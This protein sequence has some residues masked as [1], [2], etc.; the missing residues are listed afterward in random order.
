MKGQHFDE[1]TT[2]MHTRLLLTLAA[3]FAL[4]QSAWAVDGETL[5]NQSIVMAA[6][7]FPYQITQSGSYKL[8]G[9]LV[10]T[11]NVDA[12]EI[13]A[14]NVTLDLNGFTIS[15]NVTTGQSVGVG[16]GNNATTVRNGTISGF[17]TAVV[18]G[19]TSNIVE[20][21]KVV[22]SGTGFVLSNA[23]VRRNAVSTTTGVGIQ[24]FQCVITE[25]FVSE[26]PG[27]ALQIGTSLYGS[28]VLVAA[29]PVADFIG[30]GPNVS[31]NNNSCNGQ[32]C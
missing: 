14:S 6:G 11:T 8:S 25:N 31:Q 7:G 23:V 22:G 13:S 1:R 30:A 19:G 27:L 28:N 15:S 26:S 29:V 17:N 20:E 18:L 3:T 4:A 9:N 24:C 10:V 12:I 16:N 5:I 32:S 2:T 21:I